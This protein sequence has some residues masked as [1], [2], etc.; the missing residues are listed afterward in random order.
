MSITFSSYPA[1]EVID[2]A[3]DILNE[4]RRES[5]TD[6]ARCRWLYLDNPDGEATIW[7]AKHEQTVA[8]FAALIPRRMWLKGRLQRAWN[9]SD[10]S[11]RGDYRRQ[12]IAS[13]LREHARDAVDANAVD[14]LYGNPNQKSQGAHQKAGF[15]RLASMQRRVRIVE[16]SAYIKRFVPLGK[17]A[18]KISPL[19]DMVLNQVFG[20]PRALVSTRWISPTAFDARFD[21]L[22]RA[23]QTL[24]AIQGVRDSSYLNWRYGDNPYE[25]FKVAIA[26]Q[27]GSLTGYAVLR[28]ID[29]A[30]ECVDMFPTDKAIVTESLL[31]AMLR[32][33]QDNQHSSLVTTWLEGHP[34]ESMLERF[35]FKKRPESSPMYTYAPQSSEDRKYITR[36]TN[37]LVS[38]GDRDV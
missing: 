1:S 24:R 33:A 36:S 29:D 20:V 8:G 12:G 27:N 16:S 9:T 25:T 10:L 31:A 18:K 13:E 15:H 23:N 22:D 35:G 19:G 28:S 30:L 32:F 5:A 3:V 37:W 14:F 38:A 26:E 2:E 11:V 4:T 21:E 17:L 7:M 6:P 34:L